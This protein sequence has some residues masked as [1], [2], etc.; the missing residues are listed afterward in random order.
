[1]I[2][3]YRLIP[4]KAV[5]AVRPITHKYQNGLSAVK[6]LSEG[7]S[8]CNLLEKTQIAAPMKDMKRYFPCTCNWAHRAFTKK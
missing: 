3:G 7:V 4:F 8:S 1:M 2:A 6:G 5:F